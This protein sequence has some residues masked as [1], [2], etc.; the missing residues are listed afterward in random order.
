MIKKQRKKKK[1]SSVGNRKVLSRKLGI[2]KGRGDKGKKKVTLS[3]L[4][5]RWTLEH[6]EVVALWQWPDP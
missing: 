3:E 6:N 4:E 2:K 5:T 1:K